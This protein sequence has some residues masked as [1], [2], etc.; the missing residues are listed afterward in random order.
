MITK[1]LTIGVGIINL[2]F[3][4]LVAEVDSHVTKKPISDNLG[5]HITKIDSLSQIAEFQPDQ[6][7]YLFDIDD[8]LFDSS[9]MLGSKAWRKYI[10]AATKDDPTNNWHDLFSLFLARNHPLETVEPLTS[11]FIK[12]LQ[13]KG[14]GVFGL[15][16]RERKSWYDTPMNGIDSLT[17]FQL[18]S[19][20]ISFDNEFLNESY[21]D[22]TNDSEYFK[23]V[24]FADLEPKGEYLLKLFLNAP[25]LPE[26]VIFVDDKLSQVES[27]ATAL[28][29]LGID[30]ECYWYTATDDKAS[31]FNPLI[32]NI[33]LYHFCLS[34]G[35]RVI[36][37]EEA[38][39]IAMQYPER[40][41]EYYLQ[42]L[43]NA[44]IAEMIT[45]RQKNYYLHYKQNHLF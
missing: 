11:P 16:S 8:T 18:E 30:H 21:Q 1:F 27:V 36:S 6:T 40:D 3:L 44:E 29:Q 2:A 7:I 28:N 43:L 24:F 10:T 14:Y 38:G 33:Q 45:N 35:E 32:A 34:R 17:V 15:T 39:T 42:S 31:R 19:L 20:G 41:T 4:P 22:L 13:L 37:D 23:G 26:K 9:H 5:I 12:E 25:Q